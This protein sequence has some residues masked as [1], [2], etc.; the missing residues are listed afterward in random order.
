MFT[1]ARATGQCLGLYQLVSPI[2]KGGMGEVWKGRDTR[3]NRDV[4]IK[5][6][7]AEFIRRETA[8]GESMTLIKET[9]EL[10]DV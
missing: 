10:A 8:R 7:R 9:Q 1:P 6:S 5:F 2:G 3:L 4:A